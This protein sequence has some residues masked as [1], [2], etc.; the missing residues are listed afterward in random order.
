M[1]YGKHYFRYTTTKYG[2]H[3]ITYSSPSCES[4][5]INLGDQSTTFS[6]LTL[7]SHTYCTSITMPLFTNFDMRK[8]GITSLV[9]SISIYQLKSSLKIFCLTRITA[10]LEGDF[11]LCI[12]P[13]MFD[14]HSK[15]YIISKV[16][17]PFWIVHFIKEVS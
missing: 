6:A 9:Y 1:A 12:E 10:S 3:L 16:L 17:P 13:K 8:Q 14:Y 11:E 2:N 5:S 4:D 7:Q 15:A